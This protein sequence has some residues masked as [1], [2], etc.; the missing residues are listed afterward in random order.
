VER[1]KQISTLSR[2]LEEV[3][4]WGQASQLLLVE[5]DK[6][7]S[8]LSHK[9]EEVSAWGQASQLLLVERDEQISALDRSVHELSEW[10]T[11]LQSSVSERDSKISMFEQALSAK[12]AELMKMSDWAYG[13]MQEL[14]RRNASITIRSKLLA[15]RTALYAR[16]QLS[17]TLL[18]DIVQ[19]FRDRRRCRE[20]QVSIEALR[21]SLKD[22]HG[23]LVV[24]FPVITWDFRWQRPQHIVSR[25]RDHG[26]SVLYLAMSLTAQGR[27]LRG[28]KDALA[29]ARFNEL[30]RHISQI[31]LSTSNQLNIYTDPL[32]G[33]DLFNIS[34]GLSALVSELR[35]K[36][37]K[38][39]VQFPGWWPVV[40]EV[41]KKL[42]GKV[43][44]D[45][46]DDHGGFST[47]TKQALVTEDELVKGADLVITSSDLLE[48]RA[49][50]VNPNT[51]KVKNGTEFEHF[52]NP[53]RNGELD[54][55]CDR[56]I[57]GYYGAISDWFDMEIVA[58]CA[59]KR[60]GWCF[61][62]IGATFG[63]DLHP[64]EGL[65]NVH[66]LGEKPYND[67]PGYLAYFDVCTIPFKII[68]LT[69][70]TNPVKFYEYLS[71]GKP[72]VVVELPELVAYQE[73]CYLARNAD[74]FLAL[75]ER[76]YGER[77]DEKKIERRI[78]MAS[79]NSWDSR[80]RGILE[81][82]IF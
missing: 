49:K 15:K 32:E 54:H 29:E 78:K 51:I 71:A 41:K 4:A 47:N 65:E 67:L 1:D 34:M 73:D 8:A 28:D 68:P 72:V 70:A 81:S 48:Q 25:L 37:I 5:R 23:R 16:Q 45:C 11:R 38:Y 64:V 7:I 31:W 22:N 82:S 19:H 66:F 53:S 60:P 39:L 2:K 74:E 56:P 50:Q 9:L 12:Q 42:G 43:I 6:Q 13:M 46:M 75:L 20:K 69:L 33:D 18:G 79:E 14:E 62:L 57:I 61:V 26:Y 80:V 24:V 3:S 44:F 17:Q 27:R 59:R 52:A 77:D 10:R 36:S 35:P 21:R 63:A 58:H 40:K 55:L 30:D 76:A